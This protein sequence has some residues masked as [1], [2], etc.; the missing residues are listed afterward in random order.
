MEQMHCA[1]RGHFPHIGFPQLVRHR[2]VW[3]RQDQFAV[4]ICGRPKLLFLDEPTL[5]LVTGLPTRTRSLV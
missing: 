3:G 5:G 2:S 4:A 1:K